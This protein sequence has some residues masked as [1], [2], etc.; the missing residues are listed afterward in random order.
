MNRDLRTYI[1]ICHK[2]SEICAAYTEHSTA[3]FNNIAKIDVD[4]DII[5]PQKKKNGREE[6]INEDRQI[7]FDKNEE[8]MIIIANETIEPN[9]CKTI[10]QNTSKTVQLGKEK[11]FLNHLNNL[12]EAS[13]M[14]TPYR[15]TITMDQMMGT[16]QLDEIFL[17]T[18]EIGRSII[19]ANTLR[20]DTY[21][22]KDPKI[23]PT[24]IHFKLATGPG[25]SDQ[26][27][28]PIRS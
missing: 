22:W 9:A 20:A 13:L 27:Q 10:E 2:E 3:H 6:D 8:N 17:L 4:Y 1:D 26:N 19:I 25:H 12:L 24:I 5:T 18:N 15:K 7:P 16:E 14:T 28:L 21:N 11:D 23:H